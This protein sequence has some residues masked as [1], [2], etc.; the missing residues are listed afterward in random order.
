AQPAAGWGG[1]PP[2]WLRRGAPRGQAIGPPVS[3]AGQRL[4][5][6]PRLPVCAHLWLRRR[7]GEERAGGEW[8]RAGDAGKD[9]AAGEPAAVPRRSPGE[10]RDPRARRLTADPRVRIPRP[11][12]GRGTTHPK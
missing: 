12:S 8:L 11:R 1:D 7:V 9:G 2:A 5:D 6:S 10:G 4:P 3:N